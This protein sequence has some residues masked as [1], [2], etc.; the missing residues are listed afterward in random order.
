M[1]VSAGL[2]GDLEVRQVAEVGVGVATNYVFAASRQHKKI[3]TSL[4]QDQVAVG[5]GR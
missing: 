1:G 5:K 2:Q 4:L 3:V